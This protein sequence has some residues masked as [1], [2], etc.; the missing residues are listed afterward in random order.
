MIIFKL[1]HQNQFFTIQNNSVGNH[2]SFHPFDGENS[3]SFHG[4]IIAITKEEIQHINFDLPI[5]HHQFQIEEKSKYLEK[6]NN[7]I[8]LIQKEAI[9]KLVIARKKII[10]YNEIKLADSFLNLCNKYPTAFVYAFSENN[11]AWMGAFSEVL[12]CFNKKTK[13]FSTMS[14]AGTLPINEAW[15]KKEIEEQK[16]VSDFIHQILS[17]YA[18]QVQQSETYDHIS[19]KIKHLR[20]DFSIRTD[21]DK[22]D[23]IIQELHPTPA[24]CGFPKEDCKN[25]IKNLEQFDRELYAG[26]S[27]IETDEHLYAFVN[28]RCGKFYKNHAELFVGGGITKDSYPEKEWQ[29]TELKSCALTDEIILK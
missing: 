21:Y 10:P 11:H 16:P 8:K 24:V 15:T 9:P 2:L 3:L 25:W 27:R 6:I 14:L 20:T 23:A 13:V 12:G 26:Y 22:I 18:D 7:S 5:A 19:G 4:E 17:K 1:P 29:E 28:L